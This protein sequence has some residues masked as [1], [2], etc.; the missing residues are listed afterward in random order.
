MSPIESGLYN[1]R[2]SVLEVASELGYNS[3]SEVEISLKCCNDCGIWLK[4]MQLD[5]DGN[6]ICK[7]CYNT[8]GP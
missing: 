8:I 2:K 5:L 6:D 7:V 4:H 1:T 3:Y